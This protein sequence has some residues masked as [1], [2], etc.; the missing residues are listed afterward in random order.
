LRH[1]GGKKEAAMP[2]SLEERAAQ[3]RERAAELRQLAVRSRYEENR[4]QLRHLAEEFDALAAD[5]D[6]RVTIAA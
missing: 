5:V 6:E 3:Y 4:R 1:V 2:L